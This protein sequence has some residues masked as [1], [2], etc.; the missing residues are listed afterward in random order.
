MRLGQ[1]M[2]VNRKILERIIS[3]AEL[4]SDDVVLEVG[5]GT[6]NLTN[7]L[8]S[9]A[10]VIG[11]EKDPKLVKLL[12]KRFRD[13]IANG[14]FTLIHGDA[15]KIKFPKFTKC[16]SNIPYEISS[17]LIFKL[18]R[19]DFKL[20]VLMLQREFAERLVG[21]DSRLGVITKAYCR[22]KLL[23]NVGRE[24]FKPIPRVD[25]AIVKL[26]PVPMV[27]VKDLDLFEKFVTFAFSMRRKKLGKI[28]REFEERYGYRFELDENMAE[29]RP[30]EIGAVNFARIVNDLRTR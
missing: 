27:E 3:Y 12:E 18:L 6:G 14:K 25:S 24:N 5:C 28:V 30:E 22:A 10:R 2:L 16:V 20:A 29:K 7:A 1:H 17:P 4:D 8:I 15:L 19:H 21:E 11:I 9:R 26:E 23:E 13:E